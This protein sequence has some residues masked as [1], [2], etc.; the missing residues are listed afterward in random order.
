MA[1]WEGMLLSAGDLQEA[2]FMVFTEAWLCGTGPA[3]RSAGPGA[4]RLQRQPPHAHSRATPVT[5]FPAE[6]LTPSDL[7]RSHFLP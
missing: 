2:E 7:H 6:K 3:A 1:S 4:G 5:T